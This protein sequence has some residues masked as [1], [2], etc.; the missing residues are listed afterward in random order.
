MAFA[1]KSASFH[2]MTMTNFT[3]PTGT[4]MEIAGVAV[5]V[6]GMEVTVAACFGATAGFAA[7]FAMV[8]STAGG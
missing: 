6:P 8:G 2:G 5:K 7:G 1:I 3:F 4:F